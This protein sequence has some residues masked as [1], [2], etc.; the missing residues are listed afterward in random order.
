MILLPSLLV[1]KN[2]EKCSTFGELGNF[3]YKSAATTF[4]VT[5]TVTNGRGV[6]G[7]TVLLLEKC[8]DVVVELKIY[9]SRSPKT[10]AA[11][12]K[13]DTG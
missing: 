4:S 12:A 5:K 8:Y 10:S 9:Q 6:L 11:V 3:T 2:F 7:H 13:W 1:E